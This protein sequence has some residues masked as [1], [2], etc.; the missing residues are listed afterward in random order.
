MSDFQDVIAD[1]VIGHHTGSDGCWVRCAC[2]GQWMGAYQWSQH[3]GGQ[4]LEVACS[5]GGFAQVLTGPV[6]DRDKLRLIEQWMRPQYWSVLD[7][8]REAILKILEG[9]WVD[10]PKY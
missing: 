9:E 3:V 1:A 8:R 10:P 4:V 5:A 6:G 7:N 2:S